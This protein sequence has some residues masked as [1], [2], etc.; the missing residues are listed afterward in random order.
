MTRDGRRVA[1]KVR[2]PGIDCMMQRD[3][4]LTASMM[5]MLGVLPRYGRC[6]SGSCTRRW[7][8]RSCGSWTSRPRPHR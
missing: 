8:G 3:F 4:A 5:G 7:A 2:R 6:R 1:V